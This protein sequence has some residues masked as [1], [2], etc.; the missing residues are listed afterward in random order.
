VWTF[1]EWQARWNA[2]RGTDLALLYEA[3]IGGRTVVDSLGARFNLD[4]PFPVN[5]V[6]L[7]R[8]AA[9]LAYHVESRQNVLGIDTVAIE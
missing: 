3:L 5:V 9:Y 8:R 4:N 2:K 1:E 6:G 7:H